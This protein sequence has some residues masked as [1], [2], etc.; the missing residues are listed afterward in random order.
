MLNG[1]LRVAY[2]DA[3]LI[4]TERMAVTDRLRHQW[5]L[6]AVKHPPAPGDEH[7]E[8]SRLAAYRARILARFGAERRVALVERMWQLALEG[9]TAAGDAG[10]IL[11]AAELLGLSAEEVRAARERVA[12]EPV[13][14]DQATR[15]DGG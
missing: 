1:E 14:P 5:A 10:L 2:A 7:P 6:P 9:P 3:S 12:G 8:R 11:P 15:G 4:P 13:P